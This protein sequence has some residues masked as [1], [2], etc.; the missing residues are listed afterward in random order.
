[1]KRLSSTPLNNEAPRSAQRQIGFSMIEAMIVGGLLALLSMGVLQASLIIK[2][3]LRANQHH[4]AATNML[5]QQVET[6]RGMDYDRLGIRND[7]LLYINTDIVENDRFDPNEDILLTNNIVLTDMGTRRRNDDVTAELKVMGWAVDDAYDGQGGADADDDTEDYIRVSIALNWSDGKKA[8][9]RAF[10]TFVYG[11]L[12]N[13]GA[14]EIEGPDSAPSDPDAPDDSGGGGS[15]DDDDDDDKE[16][17]EDDK[18]DGSDGA[19]VITKAEYKYKDSKLKVE[20]YTDESGT[21]T[22]RVTGYAS[23]KY[24]AKK[25]NYKY[26]KKGVKDPGDYVEVTSSA[27]GSA[28]HYVKHK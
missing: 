10:D 7:N 24:D 23:M 1:M 9:S 17:D 20:A 21:P 2:R 6:L 12:L 18:D 13:H 4:T 14:M 25:D 15:P 5:K 28:T 3:G 27:G 8:Y 26:D 11:E 22:L 19:V 16:E